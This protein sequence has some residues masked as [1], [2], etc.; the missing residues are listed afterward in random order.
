MSAN[1]ARTSVGEQSWLA[2]R[3]AVVALL[4]LLTLLFAARVLGQAL[5]RW[6][7][8]SFMPPFDAF[9]G[10][11]LPY[12]VLLFAQLIILALMM[13]AALRVGVGALSPSP[14]QLRF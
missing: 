4:G 13:R 14:G 10:S 7:P 3:R 12:P 6:W 9:Q 11:G 1:S 5:Q 8:Q 2:S